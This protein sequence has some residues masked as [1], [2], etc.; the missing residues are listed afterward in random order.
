MFV[1]KQKSPL[2]ICRPL[3]FLTGSGTCG[4]SETGAT[5][6]SN[7]SL[8]HETLPEHGES[9]ILCDDEVGLSRVKSQVAHIWHELRCA[10]V[11]HFVPLAV[12]DSVEEFSESL[13]VQ[14][15]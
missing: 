5:F 9:E 3:A 12:I 10:E 2:A 13:E 7:F 1:L 14:S 4:L 6:A 15:T 8:D 11:E